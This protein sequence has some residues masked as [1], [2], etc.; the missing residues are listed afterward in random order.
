M[1]INYWIG[2]AENVAQ[3]GTGSIDTVDG[4]PAN[5]TF[6]VTIGGESI[7]Q[8]GDTDVG[9]T[10]AALVV[11]LNL[12]TNILFSGIT[13]ANPSAGTIT[14]TA[15]TAGVPFIA[16]L[17]VTGGGTGTVTDFA[18]TT[19]NSGSN[20]WGT[21]ANFSLGTVPV[22]TDEVIIR[23]G[24]SNIFWGL[25]QNGVDL[26][27]LRVHNTYT[28]KIGLNREKFTTGSDPEAVDASKEEYRDTYLKIGADRVEIGYN[29]NASNPTGSGRIKIDNDKAGA[30]EMIVFSTA[31]LASETG[32]PA[33]RFLASNVNIDIFVRLAGG[34]VGIGVDAPDETPTVGDITITDKSG[35]TRVIVGSGATISNFTQDGGD[36]FLSV[37]D[38]VTIAAVLING[39]T[40]T[41][42]GG[43][44]ITLVTME[45]GTFNANHADGGGVKI[46]TAT[47]N[48]GTLDSTGSNEARTWTTVNLE[49]GGTLVANPDNLTVTTLNKPS[50]P[51]TLTAS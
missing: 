6:T 17:T 10:A 20:D 48:G 46:V 21:A 11:L 41:T 9:T 8:V 4:T 23:D 38:A 33:V 13:W 3:L 15:D 44:D 18:A 37:D 12:S 39:G 28:G 51:Y 19:A 50:D 22:N 47:I 40:L 42:E 36:N 30:A 35:S 16:L 24:S 32:L 27:L 43:F 34:G 1:A 29:D 2:K 26:A 45:A 7:S 14:A 49:V 31:T 25:D 5:N